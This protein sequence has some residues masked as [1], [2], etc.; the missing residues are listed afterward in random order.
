M[1]ISKIKNLLASGNISANEVNPLIDSIEV[2]H[3]GQLS[4]LEKNSLREIINTI[5]L[6][7]QDQNSGVYINNP[8]KAESLL[9]ALG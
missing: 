8:D 9:E 6:L 4:E 2:Q 3:F 5:L 1:N 7:S